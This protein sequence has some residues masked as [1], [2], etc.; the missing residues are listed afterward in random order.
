MRAVAWAV[1]RAFSF[2][3][4]QELQRLALAAMRATDFGGQKEVWCGPWS[5]PFS[6]ARPSLVGRPSKRV[7]T[8]RERS[9]LVG[10]GKVLSI[11]TLTSTG[12]LLATS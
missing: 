12:Q 8:G 11:K 2:G 4:Q 3:G 7:E 6:S 5:S 1:V 9:R 10:T